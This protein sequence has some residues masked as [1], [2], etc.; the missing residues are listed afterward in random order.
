MSSL[1]CSSI[2]TNLDCRFSC[3][4]TRL[5]TTA[6]DLVLDATQPDIAIAGLKK[7]SALRLN[8]LLTLRYSIIQRQ[9]GELSIETHKQIVEK[10][11][12]LIV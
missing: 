1:V 7:P 6:T 11:Y 9:L 10:V 4:S 12:A 3:R 8:H 5:D 2:A